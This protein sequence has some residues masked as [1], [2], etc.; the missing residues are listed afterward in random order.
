MKRYQSILVI[1]LFL[2]LGW[3]C[4][5]Q[6]VAPSGTDETRPNVLFVFYDQL[7]ADVLGA[8]G[9][10][11]N[12][13]TPHLDR[14]A[15]KGVLF[16]NGL[17]ST[18]V[19][20]PYRG[21]LMTGRYPTHTG[22]MLNFVE[23]NP[24][25][26][27]IAHVFGD[28]GYRTAFIGKWHLA[29]GRFKKTW[30]GEPEGGSELAKP[31]IEENPDYDFVPPGGA[32]LGFKDWAAYNFHVEFLAAPYYRDEP[33]QLVMQ[34]FES[35]AI[36]NMGIEYMEE[37]RR[38]GEPFFLVLAPHPPHPP[39]DRLPEGYLEKVPENLHWDDNVPAD[40]RGGTNYTDARG[41]Y[42]MC[43]NADDN[44]GRLLDYLESSGLE[45]DTLVVFTSD[46][47]EM[48]GSHGRRNKMVPYREAVKVPLILRWPGKIGAG[49]R[50]D[51][52]YTP[53]DH[54]P[55]L[56]ALA[57]LEAP[58]DVDGVDLSPELLRGETIERDAVL[59]ANYSANWD[60]FRTGSQPAGEWPEWR[61]V[62]T[63][64]YTYV[65]WLTGD[66]ELYDDENDPYQLENLAEDPAHAT[67]VRDLEAKLVQFLAEAHDEFPPGTAYIEWFDAERNC[68]RTGLG[69][70]LSR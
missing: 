38:A 51:T 1:A 36:T 42:A 19:C 59:M 33:E 15:R 9:G 55:T 4:G 54:M 7:R 17:S 14:L 53:M 52:L 62:K 50:T 30:V 18:P 67:T 69:P 5:A 32:R 48:M 60:F 23:A 58:N 68:I 12:I 41:Y 11:Q 37:A 29:A 24:N 43:K 49:I 47:G 26:R 40:A 64:R 45:Q 65:R 46:H 16:T 31:Y 13:T 21:M 2:L 20:T 3:S 28:A 61:G 10:G 27:G 56:S 44:V 35:D 6:D 22:I 63:K 39:F 70:V 57:G 8:Y 25:L 34:G 66:I